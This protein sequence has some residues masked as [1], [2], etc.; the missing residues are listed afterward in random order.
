MSLKS[1][2]PVFYLFLLVVCQLQAQSKLTIDISKKGVKV[3]PT[4]SGL[5]FEDINHAA[6]GGLYAELIRNRSFEDAAT[7]DTWSVTKQTGAVATAT[8]ET[9]N[10]LNTSQSRALKLKVDNATTLARAG[11]YS[12]T[13]TSAPSKGS[14]GAKPNPEL[15]WWVDRDSNPEPTT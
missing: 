3:S 1:R 13:I 11:E 5:F 6:D 12:T 15:R 10:L 9:L 4:Q 8:I 14:L 2:I 7:L